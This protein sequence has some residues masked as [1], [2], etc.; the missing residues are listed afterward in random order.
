[1]KRNNTKGRAS[2]VS[3]VVQMPRPK[4]QP[5][6]V[7][8]VQLDRG[9]VTATTDIQDQDKALELAKRYAT[10]ESE[11]QYGAELA[12]AEAE[13]TV[14]VQQ[15]AEIKAELDITNKKLA[16]E[17]LEIPASQ[18]NG[19]AQG[20]AETEKEVPLRRWQ[21]R[22]Q[23]SGSLII[24]AILGLLVASYAGIHATLADAGLPIFEEQWHLPLMLAVLAP[25]AGIAIKQ[26]TGV[27]N[28]P[29]SKDRYRQVITAIGILAFFVWVPLFASL[30]EGLSGVFDP[31][32]ETNH[33]IAWGFN[34]GHIIAEALISAALF[35]QLDALMA[36]YAPSGLVPNEARPPLERHRDELIPKFEALSERL[37]AA[38]GR[39]RSLK[40]LYAGADVL[41][42]TAVVQR[43]NR[44]PDDGLL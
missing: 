42:E 44:K 32:K 10:S 40:A 7:R 18:G 17:P 2:A 39:V 36:K 29:A 9:I 26:A 37:G 27:F 33:F 38:R 23:F 30:F 4:D 34:V 3:K 6:V 20:P 8:A 11:L 25:A 1:M 5:D 19:G 43:M 22:D 16:A 28:D 21:T 41:V 35:F 12:A 31:F 14:V 13:E 15:Y 24:L